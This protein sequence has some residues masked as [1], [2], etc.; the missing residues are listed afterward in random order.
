M[1]N[2]SSRL[3]ITTL[4]L[5]MCTSFVCGQWGPGQPQI[6]RTTFNLSRRLSL[7]DESEKKEILIPVTGRIVSFIIRISSEIFGGELTV[8]IYDPNGEKQGNY[9][10]DSQISLKPNK[11]EKNSKP[12]TVEIVAGKIEKTIEYPTSGNWKVLII[13]KNAKGDLI[14]ESNQMSTKQILDKPNKR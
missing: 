7:N 2:F 12:S 10:V 13:P 6:D 4:F 11:N 9:S 1:E 14:I 8:E 5:T 3:L